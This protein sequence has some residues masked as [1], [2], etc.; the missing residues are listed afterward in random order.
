MSRG[1]VIT[2]GAVRIDNA[3]GEENGMPAFEGSVQRYLVELDLF[4]VEARGEWEDKFG[5]S[6]SGSFTMSRDGSRLY[7]K[8]G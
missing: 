7:F 3:D 8:K 1:T 2:T 6:Y 5:F 4:G